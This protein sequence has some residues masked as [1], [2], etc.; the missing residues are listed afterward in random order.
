MN[1]LKKI[2]ALKGATSYEQLSALAT[3]QG[4]RPTVH[5]DGTGKTPKIAFAVFM[6]KLKVYV[7][8]EG[9]ADAMPGKAE[10]TNVSLGLAGGET[11]NWVEIRGNASNACYTFTTYKMG[12]TYGVVLK[13]WLP[14]EEVRRTATAVERGDKFT[15][16]KATK[17]WSE[18]ATAKS[19]KE[20]MFKKFL[21][22]IGE[23]EKEEVMANA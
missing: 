6:D 23:D 15:F 17:T 22:F 4:G 20:D 5:L 21:T 19:S 1:L 11:E 7:L 3:K 13:G 14:G 18:K 9:M 2:E 16:D 8:P 10:L 12:D